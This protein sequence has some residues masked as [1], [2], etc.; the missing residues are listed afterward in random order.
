MGHCWGW[1]MGFMWG[2]AGGIGDAAEFEGQCLVEG[3]VER[4]G[5]LD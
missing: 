4:S 3:G 5:H 1:W 2:W